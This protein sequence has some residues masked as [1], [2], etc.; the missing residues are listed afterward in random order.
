MIDKN[1]LKPEYRG[2]GVSFF[3]GERNNNPGNITKTPKGGHA[4]L[5]EGESSDERFGTYI[6]AAYGLRAILVLINVY[7]KKYNIN[8]LDGVAHRW[9]PPNENNSIVYGNTLA[10]AVGIPKTQIYTEI[11]HEMAPGILRGI[12]LNENGRVIYS[13]DTIDNA[14]KM[15]FG[16]SQPAAQEKPVETDAKPVV[17]DASQLLYELVMD[18]M[19]SPTDYGMEIKPVGNF[20]IKLQH[21]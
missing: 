9:A 17:V 21:K 7:L 10:K 16:E 20:V 6:S 1:E 11:T 8:T 19:V 13:D 18:V 15:F 2:D 14:V 12:C 5:G 4:F 3:R